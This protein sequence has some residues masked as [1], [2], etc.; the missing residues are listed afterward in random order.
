MPAMMAATVTALGIVSSILCPNR[1]EWGEVYSW[2][3]QTTNVPHLACAAILADSSEEELIRAPWR[4]SIG[5][6]IGS[7]DKLAMISV[8]QNISRKIISVVH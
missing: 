1:M 5:T 6:D 7:A 4:Y 8:Y 3:V 2:H